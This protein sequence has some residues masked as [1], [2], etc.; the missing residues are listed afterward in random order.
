MFKVTEN[1]YGLWLKIYP[2]YISCFI[3][4]AT[5]MSKYFC[6][7]FLRPK[8]FPGI[9]KPNGRLLATSNVERRNLTLFWRN[10]W[11]FLAR[12]EHPFISAFS[13]WGRGGSSSGSTSDY[14]S[15]GPRFD[16]CWEL[17]FFLFSS[18]SY[19][20][21]VLNQVPWGGATL[22]IFL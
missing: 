8:L 17:A 7:A 13:S 10:L 2:A 12:V 15:R 22:L 5:S 19:Q 6:F 14:G 18:Q 4:R 3:E 16:S 9:L 1:F 11:R 21:C 20:K